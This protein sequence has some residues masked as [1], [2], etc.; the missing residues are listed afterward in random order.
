MGLGT[1]PVSALMRVTWARVL[2]TDAARREAVHLETLFAE[3]V[4]IAGRIVV[5][6]LLAARAA[7][8]DASDNKHQRLRSTTVEANEEASQEPRS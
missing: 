5:S 2:T 8:P 4:H 6:I 3:G 7:A 1:V